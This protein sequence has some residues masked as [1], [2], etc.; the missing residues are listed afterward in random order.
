MR[1]SPSTPF[2]SFEA[3]LKAFI[4]DLPVTTVK[5]GHFSSLLALFRS[6]KVH[7]DTSSIQDRGACHQLINEKIDSS[8]RMNY[9][10][11][12]Y[13][14]IVFMPPFSLM[15]KVG[16]AKERSFEGV[17]YRECLRQY[18]ALHIKSTKRIFPSENEIVDLKVK[19]K[20]L[21]ER[22]APLFPDTTKK[23][24]PRYLQ[25]LAD[26][27]KRLVQP[28]RSENFLLWLEG[29]DLEGL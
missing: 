5:S 28:N 10:Q 3:N 14:T 21:E 6:N 22:L 11:K 7:I 18:L 1:T 17:T 4:E 13:Y 19:V 16:H 2:S 24:S 12:M 23:P 15:D 25:A 9:P 20:C 8:T 26:G 27:V 29:L